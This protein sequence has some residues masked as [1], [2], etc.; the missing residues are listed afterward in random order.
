MTSQSRDGDGRDAHDLRAPDLTDLTVVVVPLLGGVALA[1]CVSELQRQG[2]TIIIV[3]GLD[4]IERFDGVEIVTSPAGQEHIPGRRLCGLMAART[5]FI[6]FIEDTCLPGPDWCAAL[7]TAF[8]DTELA[9]IGGPVEI[10]SALAPRQ[11]ALGIAEYARFQALVLARQA[12]GR[13][14][15]TIYVSSLAGA[16]FA[17]RRSA[18]AGVDAAPM[19]ID[20]AMFPRILATGGIAS[21]PAAYATYSGSDAH[22]ARL[23]TRFHHG[24]IFGGGRSAGKSGTL[25][26]LLALVALAVPALLFSRSCRDAPRW[27]WRSPA[28]LA[29]VMLMHTA[30]GLGESFG[31][32]SGRVGGSLEKWT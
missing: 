19:M 5:P 10:S 27:M 26:V 14:S 17:V 30:W 13:T 1:E 23:S 18:L 12:G 7:R 6:A 28:T 25:R 24:R 22:G 2:A 4:R 32:A 15:Q 31:A 21:V 8:A 9:A 16:N 20:N 3:S 29:W 11:R